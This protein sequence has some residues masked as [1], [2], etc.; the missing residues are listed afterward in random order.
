MIMEDSNY[1]GGGAAP[2][3]KRAAQA[4]PNAI[5]GFPGGPG[6]TQPTY[7]T[8]GR[9]A[10]TGLNSYAQQ[11]HQPGANSPKSIGAPMIAPTQQPQ[12]PSPQTNTLPAQQGQQP[13][14][15]GDVE[16][17]IRQ[18]LNNPSPF[19][20]AEFQAALQQ[21]QQGLEKTLAERSGGLKA[22]A[23][24]RGVYYGSPL[25]AGLGKAESAFADSM[26][27]LNTNLLLEKA[28]TQGG[29]EQGAIQDALGLGGMQSGINQFDRTQSLNEQQAREAA[30]QFQAQLG[31]NTAALG[32]GGGPDINSMFGNMLGMPIPGQSDYSGLFGGLGG[33]AGLFSNL[34]M[35][36]QPQGQPQSYEG[37]IGG[38]Y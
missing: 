28:R 36:R 11:Q 5:A 15:L 14:I 8:S 17:K 31:L 25:T 2:Q 23:A 29:Y 7:L 26:S 32:Y 19:G 9:G 33:L 12:V 13:A 3:Q 4:R 37:G 35:Q 6:N 24:S 34:G 30:E 21:G 16:E 10:A 38:A 18:R 1:G 27:N 22:D 20:S